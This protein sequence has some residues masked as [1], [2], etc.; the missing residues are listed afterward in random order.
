MI[1]QR[2]TNLPAIVLTRESATGYGYGQTSGQLDHDAEGNQ[3]DADSRGGLQ[4]N[5]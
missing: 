3:K 1:Q 4:S 5:S 2:R